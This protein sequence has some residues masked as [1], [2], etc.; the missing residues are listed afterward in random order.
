MNA[1]HRR[2]RARGYT[3]AE[4]L[5]ASALLG[6]AIGAAI[7][8][9]A[10]INTQYVA[11]FN[12]SV[13]HNYQDNGARLWQLGLSSTEALALLPDIRDNADLEKSVVPTST[14]ADKQLT[15]SAVTNSTLALSMG[16][17]EKSTCTVTM[18]NPVGAANRT[19]AVDAYRAKIR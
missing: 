10:T 11:S 9:S 19:L 6:L 17:V 15:F 7:A 16:T 1:L 4:V 18:K 8:L 12:Q 5:V 14:G 13:A 2:S 3:F